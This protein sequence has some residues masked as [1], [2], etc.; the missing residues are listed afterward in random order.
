MTP[1][2]IGMSSIFSDVSHKTQV[3][4]KSANRGFGVP[5]KIVPVGVVFDNNDID[6][7]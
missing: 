2:L 6:R 4:W 1:S 7:L 5:H 3:S